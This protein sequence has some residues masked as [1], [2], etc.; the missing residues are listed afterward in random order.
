[1]KAAEAKALA[2]SKLKEAR[3]IC[4]PGQWIKFLDHYCSGMDRMTAF[5]YMRFADQWKELGPELQRIAGVT[6]L[7]QKDRLAICQSLIRAAALGPHD[8]S[9]MAKAIGE[10][11]AKSI[12]RWANWISARHDRIN[13]GHLSNEQRITLKTK[14]EPVVR[15]YS[16]L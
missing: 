16:E 8:A 12:L 13:P 11:E 1:L 3:A 9:P 15:L 4:T 7:L 14:L 10:I 5:R 6:S 2:G